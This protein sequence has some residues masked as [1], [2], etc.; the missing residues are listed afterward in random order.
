V[1][2]IVI[3]S[4]VMRVIDNGINMFQLHYTDSDRVPRIWR[5]DPNWTFIIIGG[6][7]LAAVIL[8]Q[9]VHLVQQRRRI[10]G[11]GD[12]GPGGA[13]TAGGAAPADGKVAS[14]AAGPAS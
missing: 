7:I 1:L 2:G 10:R 4:A 5:L 13:G 6:V 12:A 14:G 9:S 8:D 3:G 11:A